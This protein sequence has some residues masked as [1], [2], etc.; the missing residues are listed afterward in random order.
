MKRTIFICLLLLCVLTTSAQ[1]QRTF[2]GCTLGQSKSSV[3][4]T[5]SHQG[6]YISEIVSSETVFLKDKSFGGQI[7]STLSF[8][9]KYGKFYR[10][11]ALRYIRGVDDFNLLLKALYEKYPNYYSHSRSTSMTRFFSDGRTSIKLWIEDRSG[12]GIYVLQIEYVDSGSLPQV[13]SDL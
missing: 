13:S 4:S 11:G 10:F 1:I 6:G 3:Y 8:E 12:N 5:L 9:F 2:F 7:W